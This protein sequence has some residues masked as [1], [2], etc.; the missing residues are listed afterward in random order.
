VARAGL[1][2]GRTIEIDNVA[3]DH[4]ALKERGRRRS[5]R[6]HPRGIDDHDAFDRGQPQPTAARDDARG[7]GSADELRRAKSIG[8]GVH[9]TVHATG[10]PLGDR[11]EFVAGD[12]GESLGR[13][14]PVPRL[15]WESAGSQREAS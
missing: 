3:V 7:K 2:G 13:R 15:D 6:F 14:S 10:S 8:L 1:H 5:R 12:A 9:L 4:H 11:I